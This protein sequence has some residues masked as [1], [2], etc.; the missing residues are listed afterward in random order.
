[1]GFQGHLRTLKTTNVKSTIA[2]GLLYFV[3]PPDTQLLFLVTIK[4]ISI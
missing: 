4:I 1:M 2:K 3:C